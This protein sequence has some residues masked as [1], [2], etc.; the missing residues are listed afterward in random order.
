VSYDVYLEIST[1]GPS[2]KAVFDRN[3]TSNTAS[4]W[5]EAGCDI[6]EFDGRPAR[7]FA[8]ALAE[9]I[10]DISGN[11]DYWQR[12]HAP[13]NGWGTVDTTLRFLSDLLVG[14]TLHPDTTVR[15]SR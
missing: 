3:H 11:P 1:G 4:M 2:P 14:C 15:V 8:V 5:R 10:Q 7:E 9:A 6:A 13:S 12:H